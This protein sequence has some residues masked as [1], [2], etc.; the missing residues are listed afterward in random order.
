MIDLDKELLELFNKE[1]MIA[2]FDFQVIQGRADPYSGL[3]KISQPKSGSRQS[4]YISLLFLIDAPDDT[5]WRQ[6]DT[7]ASRLDWNAFQRELAEVVTVL[8]IPHLHK[9]TGIYFKEVDIYLNNRVAIAKRFVMNQLYPAISKVMGLK[10][11]EM[12]FWDDI[13][14]NK[15]ELQSITMEK[16]TPRSIVERIKNFFG[17]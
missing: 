9:S 10:G 13:P 16:G 12:V 3:C 2:F 5:A 1:R 17:Q 15:K 6:V 14:E 4:Q 8:P 11:G 7:Y